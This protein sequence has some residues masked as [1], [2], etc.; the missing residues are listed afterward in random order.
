M[1]ATTSGLIDLGLS[2]RGRHPLLCGAPGR[3]NEAFLSTCEPSVSGSVCEFHNVV[4]PS[5]P[6]PLHTRIPTCPFRRLCPQVNRPQT[7]RRRTPTRGGWTQHPQVDQ[8][9][10]HKRHGAPALGGGRRGAHAHVYWSRPVPLAICHLLANCQPP[11][12]NCQAVSRHSS[13][14]EYKNILSPMETPGHRGQWACSATTCVPHGVAVN[15]Q[16]TRA[17]KGCHT[18]WKNGEEDRCQCDCYFGPRVP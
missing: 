2:F 12:A 13:F 11:T 18:R 7:S 5:A 17:N 15:I 8:C 14:R 9:S 16:Q 6:P 3:L 10:S 4:W 1:K